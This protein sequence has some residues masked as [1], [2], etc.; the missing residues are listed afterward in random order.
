MF[1]YRNKMF[2]TAFE[3]PKEERRKFGKTI[4]EGGLALRLV[5]F[6]LC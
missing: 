5:Q 3:W 6:V 1:A 2:T 4:R